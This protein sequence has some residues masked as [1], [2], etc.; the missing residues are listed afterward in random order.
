M[1]MEGRER[2]KNWSRQCAGSLIHIVKDRAVARRLI[3][4]LIWGG[5]Q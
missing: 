2:G 4:V 1:A 5:R 3:S